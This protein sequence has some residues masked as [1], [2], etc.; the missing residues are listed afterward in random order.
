MDDRANRA[1]LLR[2]LM[3]IRFIAV[4]AVILHHSGASWLALQS[5]TPPLV[6]N[7]LLNGTLAQGFFFVLSGFILQTLYRHRM[8]EPGAWRRY[9]VSRFARIYPVY[10]LGV[11]AVAPFV[12][13]IGWD[14]L[15]QFL[16]LQCWPREGSVTWDIWNGPSW[17]LSVEF[18]FYLVFPFVCRLVE[19]MSPRTI[20]G[21]VAAATLFIFL[22][23]SAG[24]PGGTLGPDW[25]RTVPLPI[26]RFPEFLAGVAIAE[27]QARRGIRPIVLPPG[28]ALIGF[29]IVLMFP[30]YP[31]QAAVA[32]VFSTL[33]TIG[34]A[35]NRRAM[36]TRMLD[37]KPAILLG[38]AS[39]SM[40]MLAVPVH[41]A[42]SATRLGHGVLLLQYPLIIGAAI[43]LLFVY[44]N[45]MRRWINGWSRPPTVAPPVTETLALDIAETA[46]VSAAKA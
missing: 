8:A 7:L 26:L 10:F 5:W 46:P 35:N 21:V 42:L 23:G 37:A 2:P 40:Y 32:I 29:A 3:G 30:S 20:A 1:A 19:R 25:V 43:A 36:F 17:M 15:P 33:M 11:I 12:A 44:E 16:L 45:P 38:A 27:W 28:T 22:T 31:Q 4:M 13:S 6:D 14:A 39:Y 34:L 24:P 18:A 9:A 41:A